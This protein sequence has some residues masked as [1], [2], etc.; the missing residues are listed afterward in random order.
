MI[1]YSRQ[2]TK[3]SSNFSEGTNSLISLTESENGENENIV[4]DPNTVI[5][6]DSDEENEDIEVRLHFFHRCSIPNGIKITFLILYD[7]LLAKN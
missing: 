4:D 3:D 7:R 1:G 2:V 5:L 6:L